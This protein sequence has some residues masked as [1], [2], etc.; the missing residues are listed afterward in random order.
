MVPLD[1]RLDIIFQVRLPV[2]V[3]FFSEIGDPVVLCS[4]VGTIAWV[5]GLV[6]GQDLLGAQLEGA[7]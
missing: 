4:C 7:E 5:V 2:L 1:L 6:K 3:S